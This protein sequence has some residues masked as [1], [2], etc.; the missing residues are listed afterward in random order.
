MNDVHASRG[1]TAS[2]AS[3]CKS[4]SS[5]SRTPWAQTEVKEAARG[6]QAEIRWVLDPS[7]GGR[8][9]ATEAVASML[10]ICFEKLG[11]RRV[12]ANCFAD[13]TRSWRLMERL[14]MATGGTHRV[15]FPAPIG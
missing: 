1:S 9:L 8:G 7:Y 2:T 12:V 11:V 15:R 10:R 4:G 13:N 14:G 5:Q 6:V 3:R